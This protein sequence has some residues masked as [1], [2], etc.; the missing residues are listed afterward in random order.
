MQKSIEVGTGRTGS[1]CIHHRVVTMTL[2][3]LFAYLAPITQMVRGTVCVDSATHRTDTAPFGWRSHAVV[4]CSL[5]LSLSLSLSAVAAAKSCSCKNLLLIRARLPLRAQMWSCK[6]EFRSENFIL[7]LQL[8]KRKA[9]LELQNKLCS[10]STF[11]RVC[12]FKD[13][14]LHNSCVKAAQE[15]N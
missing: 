2:S 15:Q 1:P 3:A 11:S 9:I 8:Q 12:T 6:R 13:L 14:H 4:A 10:N 5:S 7:P